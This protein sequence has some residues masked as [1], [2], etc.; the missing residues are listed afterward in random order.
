M[1]LV[2][3]VFSGFGKT[4]KILAVENWNVVPDIVCLGKSMGGGLPISAVA[5]SSEIIDECDFLALGTQGSFSGNV[6]SCAA[7]I[8]TMEVIKEERLLEK[9]SRH[10]SYI[11]KRLVELSEKY[12]IIGDVRG[13]GLMLGIELVENRKTKVPAN[14]KAKEIQNMA[15][16]KGLLLSKV[17]RYENILRLTP[18][19]VATEKQIDLGLEILE[20][21]IKMDGSKS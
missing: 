2:D 4:G 12:E 16:K 9:A 3:E 5:T 13:L 10:G 1:Y 20:E 19:L 6:I 17:G 11:M 18:H 21:A 7:T 15:Y 14:I 8:A